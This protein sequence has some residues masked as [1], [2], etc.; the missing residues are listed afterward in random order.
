MAKPRIT[1]PLLIGVVGALA[2]IIASAVA[3]WLVIDNLEA[4]N[5]SSLDAEVLVDIAAVIK[6][7]GAMASAASVPTNARMTPES[8]AEARTAIAS[9]EAQLAEHLSALEGKGHNDR[10]E[11]V[12]QQADRL[13]ANV[14][15]IEDHRPALLEAI[16]AGERS[17][18]QL[19]FS[20]NQKLLPAISSSLDNQ[21]YYVMTGKS[22]FRD[23]VGAASD[24]LSEV[25]YLRYWHLATLLEWTFSAHR[26]MLAAN[27]SSQDD[28]TRLA[29]NEESFDTA[30]QRM[31]YSI[32][33]LADNGGPE[34]DPEVIPLANRLLA[35][36]AGE[37]STL[38]AM[39]L[40]AS[41]V[42]R[43][44]QLIGANRQILAGL[45]EEV[46]GLVAE[47]RQSSA[48]DR[49]SQAVSSGR[50]VILVIAIVGIVGTLLVVGYFGFRSQRRISVRL[51]VG[52]V[53]ALA[54]IIASAVAGWLVIDNL[55][56]QSP[57]RGDVEVLA[58][59]AEITR[60]S[61]ALASA[62]SVASNVR[63]TPESIAEA[64][65]GIASNEAQLTEHLL[66]L[67]GRGYEGR[68]ERASRQVNLLTANASRIEDGRPAL[69]EA[70]LD[71]ERNWQELSIST[72]YEL[73]PAIGTSLDNQ[74]YYLMTGRSDFRDGNP[75]SSGHLSEE[76]YLRYWHM[77]TLMESLSRGYWTL[78]FANRLTIP[79]LATRVEETFDTAAQRMERSIAY[80]ADNGGPDLDPEVI[81]LANRL[82]DAG[83]GEDSA[84]DA[85]KLRTA[86]VARERKLIGANRQILAGLQEEVDELVSEVRQNVTAA[87]ARYE[88]AAT[89]G[90]III[91]VIAVIGI[92]GT[93]LMAGYNSMRG[94][95]S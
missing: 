69:L 86:M 79:A 21:F 88:Q 61:S 71:G 77:A 51:A 67:E 50:T 6:Q 59:T 3:G 94:S 87:S 66:I 43:E 8:I 41:M 83:A 63:M 84:L 54:I 24:T 85:M 57:G 40:R 39:R 28:P 14:S 30:A 31:E 48:A 44:R 74:F 27:L 5:R 90:R 47:V 80:L 91:L 60:G 56:A 58:A 11:R 68:V 18:Q 26:S 93:L 32:E 78:D 70:I 34:L 92:V 37:N 95:P 72:N 55:E 82:L 4:E 7:S 2:I 76:E 20:T 10:V 13:V 42:A 65:A 45:Q 64:G 9:S 89:N 62:A 46:N 15:R 22:D 35:A 75:P 25:E 23:D 19:L 33:Y 49:Y 38:E 16:L 17:W 52:S 29:S 1:A 53:G 12:R 73:F 81:P 36:G